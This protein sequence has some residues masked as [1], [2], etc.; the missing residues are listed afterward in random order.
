MSVKAISKKYRYNV[1][2]ITTV[3]R[4]EARVL[5]R[6][7]RA[8]GEPADQTKIVQRVVMERVVR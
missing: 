8:A 1:N 6:S 5:Q 7:L 4:N 2:G 3:T